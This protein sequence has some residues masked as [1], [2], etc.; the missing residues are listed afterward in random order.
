MVGLFFNASGARL[1]PDL[2]TKHVVKHDSGPNAWVQNGTAIGACETAVHVGGI[3]YFFL[4]KNVSKVLPVT[5]I[6]Y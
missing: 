3:S 6:T 2:H 1:S 5:V 4:G